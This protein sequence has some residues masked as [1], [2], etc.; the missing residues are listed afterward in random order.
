MRFG[1]PHVAAL[2][3]LV[4][5]AAWIYAVLDAGRTNVTPGASWNSPGHFVL[6]AAVH[7]AA[8]LAIGRWWAV[9]LTLVP[10]LLALPAGWFPTGYPELPVPL[11]VALH[12]LMYGAFAVAVGAGLRKLA[13]R[14]LAG[15]F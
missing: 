8:G 13:E 2:A 15:A 9:A 10:P 14:V 6:V 11:Y 1:F 7:V 5:M 12:M 3:Y 4:T